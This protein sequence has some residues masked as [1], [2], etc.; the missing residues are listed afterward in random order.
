MPNRPPRAGLAAIAMAAGLV[1][2]VLPASAQA[3]QPGQAQSAPA[4]ADDPLRR[5]TPRSAFMRFV[6]A[7]QR[8]DRAAAAEYLAWPRQKMPLTKEEAAEQLS[9][10]LNHGFEGNLD[11][12]SRDPGG[13]STTAWP[14][15]GNASAPPCWPT[16]SAW[17]SS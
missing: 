15:I 4:A 2:A 9:F 12:L 11:R 10:V 13:A 16:A 5:E 1:A 17:T 14:R 8:G 7:S 3:A 6:E